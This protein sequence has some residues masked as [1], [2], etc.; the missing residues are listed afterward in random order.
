VLARVATFTLDGV[1]SRRVWVE[2]DIR[3]GLPAFT[4][5]GLADKAV[6]EARE[7]VRAAIVNSGLEFPLKRITVNLA[8]AY[9]HK[10][11]PG[12]DLPLALAVLVA[13][14]Q[15]PPEALGE[16]ACCGE[17]SLAGEV[18]AVRG[19]LAVAEG[20]RHHGLRR[21]IVPRSR[22]REA[23]L[24]DGIEI[25]GV[26]TLQEVVDLLHGRAEP[27]PLPEPAPPD[28][29]GDPRDFE[30]D[31]SDVRGHNALIPAVTVAA[32]G[33]HNLFMHGPPGT[34]KTMLARRIASILPPLTREEAI[35]VTR[36]HSIAGLHDGA[37]LAARRP[38][39]APHH[40]ISPS[41]LVGGGSSPM[42]GEVTLAHHGVLFLDELS[43]FPRSSL[44][45]LRQPLEDGRVAIVRGQRLVVYPSDC[46]LVAAA[47][48]CPCGMGDARCRCTG[49]DLARHERR[50]S[51][52]LLDRI[53]L[54]LRVERP[55]A[56]ALRTQAAPASAEVRAAVT[57]ARE[58]QAERFAGH[59]IAC[60]AQMT[61]RMLREVAGATPA[62][63][64]TLYAL[65]DR[66]GLSARGHARVLRVA[67]T[68][69]DLAGSASIE[70]PH[71]NEA[72]GYRTDV[73]QRSAAA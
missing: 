5:V 15:V 12:F 10:I 28:A 60:N 56:D 32:A 8:P 34:G 64:R 35:G 17:L 63:T 1:R 66:E 9:L 24:V 61:P 16:T 3:S 39:R 43:E 6:R 36:I 62:A 13:A 40:T 46:M 53:D 2:A 26:E 50:L 25:C 59:G 7:R 11:G 33:G 38:F 27:A 19:T 44:E 18:R 67:R 45:A 23:A 69:A 37:G 21:L 58:R 22:A 54:T 48:P 14:G 68:V 49:A 71:V 70:V 52:P 51:G 20:T 73:A 29:A 72:A 42:P 65:H 47:N 55:P 30:P 4:V 41:G 31:L 57:A